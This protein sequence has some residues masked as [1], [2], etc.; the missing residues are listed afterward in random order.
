MALRSTY[1]DITAAVDWIIR[2]RDEKTLNKKQ[3]DED[4]KRRK[5]QKKLGKCANGDPVNA[6]L[7]RELKT[8]GY[9]AY[10][11]PEA[12]RQSNNDVNAAVILMSDKEFETNVLTKAINKITNRASTSTDDNSMSSLLAAA[13]AN[14]TELAASLPSG[15]ES[16]AAD[17]SLAS[18]MTILLSNP[19]A[20]AMAVNM[21]KGA[22][23]ESLSDDALASGLSPTI[24]EDDIQKSKK[25]YDTL[26]KDLHSE[27]EY[28]D[29]A[30]EPENA[31][32]AQYKALLS[33]L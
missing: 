22:L 11:I 15:L 29:L 25:A 4:M 21:I 31:Y 9:S 32:L 1:G 8:M 12:L 19:E 30:L 18:A 33:S 28:I 3:D 5:L 13:V 2:K 6:Q 14:I 10:L 26:A 20:M 24:S 27:E 17:G 7:Y 23:N 16:N